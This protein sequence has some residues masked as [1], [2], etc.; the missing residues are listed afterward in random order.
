MEQIAFYSHASIILKTKIIF[1]IYKEIGVEKF[2]KLSNSSRLY[3]DSKVLK[4]KFT[5]VLVPQDLQFNQFFF[6]QS[7]KGLLC[8]VGTK[9]GWSQIDGSALG[10]TYVFA[11]PWCYLNQMQGVEDRVKVSLLD[12]IYISCRQI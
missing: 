7:C 10:M 5:F 2:C 9:T 6:V 3:C 12:D 8:T 1:N 11:S 4:V